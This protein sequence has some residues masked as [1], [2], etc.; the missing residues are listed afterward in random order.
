MHAIIFDIDGTLLHS[1]AVDDALYREAIKTVFGKVRLRPSLHHYDFVTDTGVLSQIMADNGIPAKRDYEQ[2]VKTRFV[3]LLRGHVEEHGPFTPIPGASDLLGSLRESASHAVAIATGGWR[4]SAELK[5]ESAGF[6]YS[7]LPLATS[8]D[9]Y[10][11]T[12]IMEIALSKLGGRFESVAYYGDGTWDRNACE[13]LGWRFIAVG[14]ELGGI[15]SYIGHRLIGHRVRPMTVDDV[16]AV[17]HVRTSV[18]HNHM[19]DDDLRDIGV[20]RESV[21]ERLES[22]EIAGWCAV[23]NGKVVG[24]SMA[25]AA[26]REID[27]LFVLPGNAGTGIGDDLLNV[28]VEHLRNLA[29]GAVRLRTDPKLPAYEFYLRRGWRDTGEDHEPGD[30]DSDRLLELE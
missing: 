9:H 23:S 17:F 19:D 13:K 30:P 26:T 20:T 2:E 14:P 11:R 29:P 8:N 21:A 22:G 12:G 1:A 4:E 24:F 16:E 5:L 6:D 7:D 3:D 25:I 18:V 27:A 15:D 28:A 10:E